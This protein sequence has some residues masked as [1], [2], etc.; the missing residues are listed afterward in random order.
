[1]VL[2]PLDPRAKWS[3]RVV[4]GTSGDPLLEYEPDTQ[5]ETASIGKVFLLVEVARR[6]EA[7]TLSLDQRVAVPDE[8]GVADSGLLYLMRDKD[9]CV[10]DMALLVGAFSDNLATNALIHLCGLETVRQVAPDLGYRDTALHDYLRDERTPELPWT[11]SYGTARE[12][13]DV[14]RR[15]AAGDVV[16]AAV[17]ARVLEWLG[18]NADTTLVAD[19]FSVDSLAHL[20]PDYQGVQLR[21]KTGSTDFARVDIGFVSGPR[22]SVAYAVAANWKGLDTDL[23]VPV[24]DTMREIGEQIRFAVTGRAREDAAA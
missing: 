6:I 17:S 5:C 15:L 23:R 20:G 3:I 2:P 12:L 1:M 7:G 8:Y 10:A 4:H 11:P 24:I 9:L 18:S 22:G 13:A 14:M 16:S 21:N 19:A